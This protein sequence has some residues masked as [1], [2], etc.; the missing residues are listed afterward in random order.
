[1]SNKSNEN[2]WAVRERL[3]FIETCAWWKGLVNRQ[4]LTAVFGVSMA[5]ASSD[6]QRYLDINPDSLGYNLRLKRYEATS[7]MKCMVST[8]RIEDAVAR[9]MDGDFCASWPGRSCEETLDGNVSVLQQP[10]RQAPSIV[11]R[12]AFMAI[13]NNQRIRIRYTSTRTGKPEWRWI[14]PHALGHNG[15]RWH[16]RSWCE[17]NDGFQD[18]TLGRISE[19]EW[20]RETAQLPQPDLEWQQFVTVKVRANRNL[21]RLQRQVVEMDYGMTNGVLELRVRKAMEN[22]LR[23]RLGLPLTDGSVTGSLLECTR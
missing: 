7:E 6:M 5:Q 16:L 11:E 14:R 23:E 18:F 9:F 20:S 21:D 3:T 4:D 13:M 8:P 10:G 15:L 2:N 19:I 12:R 17:K 1:M 22:Y